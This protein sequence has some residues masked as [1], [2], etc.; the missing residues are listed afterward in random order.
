[1]NYGISFSCSAFGSEECI[2]ECDCCPLEGDCRNCYNF[3]LCPTS[4]CGME[5]PEDYFSEK[6][7]AEDAL[8][9]DD[10]AEHWKEIHKEKYEELERRINE[11]IKKIKEEG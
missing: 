1:M 3:E 5:T 4:I 8:L 7:N 9:S 2:Y 6:K 10:N 11:M